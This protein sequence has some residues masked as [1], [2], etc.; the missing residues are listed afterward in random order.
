MKNPFSGDIK[1]TS[2]ATG[3]IDPVNNSL[4]MCILIV[5]HFAICITEGI[6]VLSYSK[7]RFSCFQIVLD[8]TTPESSYK[9]KSPSIVPN[10]VSADQ[11][12]LQLNL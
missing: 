9:I 10:F 6:P 8:I 5:I 7:V 4:P 3:G 12:A 11:I 1:S 2:S